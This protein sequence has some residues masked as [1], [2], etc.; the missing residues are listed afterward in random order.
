MARPPEIGNVQL[1]PDRPLNARDKNGYVLKFYCPIKGKRI[2]KNAGTRDRR[3]ARKIL[4][5]CRERLLNGE[6]VKS[7]GAITEQQQAT[8]RQVHV[9]LQQPA[10]PGDMSWADC[11]DRYRT[12]YRARTRDKSTADALSRLSISERILK[13]DRQERGLPEDGPIAEFLNLD[14]LEYLQERLLEGDEGRY[15]SRSATTANSALAAVMAF[16][17]YCFRHGWIENLPPLTR[18]SVSEFMKGRPISEEEFEEMIDATPAVVGEMAAV[19]WRFILRVLW[20]SGFRIGDCLDFSWD[21]KRHIHPVWPSRKGE[22]PTVVVPPTQKNGKAQEIPNAA[23]ASGV[24]GNSAGRSPNGVGSPSASSDE[25]QGGISAYFGR[26][27]APDGD[28]FE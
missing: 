19:P 23:G 1:Y 5:E 2:R 25:G 13:T 17:R 3:E 7:G 9:V 24:I 26:S 8:K 22:H 27:C 16:A 18:L 20:E 28:V 6:Y 14:S 15:E 10:E 21:D 12:H 11:Y 4:R